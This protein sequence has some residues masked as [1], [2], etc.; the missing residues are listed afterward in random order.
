MIR[1]DAQ[2]ARAARGPITLFSFGY[3]GWGNATR[4]LVKAIDAVEASRGFDPPIFIE[5][6]IR[7]AGRAEGFIGDNFEKLLGRER[8]RWIKALGNEAITKKTKKR[9]QIADPDAAHELLYRAV[10]ASEKNRRVIFFCGCPLPRP[11]HR[12]VVGS[13]VLRVAGKRGVPVEVAEWP[14]GKPT[15]IDLPVTRKLLQTVAGGRSTIPIGAKPDLAHVASLAWGSIATLHS[16]GRQLHRLIGP[17]V[18]TRGKWAIP[19][20]YQF[21]DPETPLAEYRKVSAKE[22]TES[23]YDARRSP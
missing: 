12:W 20:I 17:A 18:F 5:V 14:G 4:Q 7:R 11:C 23:G 15:H 13:L 9:I 16:E 10:D 1:N 8:Y 2:H 3:W 22:R 6:R 21:Y 19:V